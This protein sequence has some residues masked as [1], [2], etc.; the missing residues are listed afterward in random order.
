MRFKNVLM[1]VALAISCVAPRFASADTL[2][3]VGTSGGSVNGVE[4]YP[5]QLSYSTGETST[6]MNMSC[7]N[8]NLE[9]SPG[10][11]WNVKVYPINDL[12]TIGLTN[13]A[14]KYQLEEAAFLFNQYGKSSVAGVG[15]VNDSEIQFA[16]WALQDPAVLNNSG[17][18]AVSAALDFDALLTVP[19]LP[20]SYFNNDAVYI[21]DLSKTSGWTSGEPQS[22]ISTVV[23]SQAPE[24][25]SLALFG[26]GLLGLSLLFRKK[27]TL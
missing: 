5:Y 6:L 11:T 4:T 17:F 14:S 25:S 1:T 15:K 21:P 9:V 23:V 16:I 3:L 7:L 24:P 10:E 22:F 26:T 13:G 8:Y 2:T 20:S 27:V 18:D 12:P 19:E